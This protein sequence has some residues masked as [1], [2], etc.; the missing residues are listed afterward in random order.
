ML[1]TGCAGAMIGRAG[2]GQPWLIAKLIAEMKNESF[3]LP[4]Q[5]EIGQIFF[6]HVEQLC[7]L[8]Q[9]EKQAILQ[10]RKIAKYYARSLPNREQWM[11]AVNQCISLDHLQQLISIWFK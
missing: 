8:L 4:T 9:N 2:V 5:I 1:A 3:I 7:L 10:A 11:M 6:R